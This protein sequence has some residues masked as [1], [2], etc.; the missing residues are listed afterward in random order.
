MALTQQQRTTVLQALERGI[1]LRKACE[2]ADIAGHATWIDECRR[3]DTL[4]DQYA[5]ARQMGY[6]LLADEI[7]EISDDSSADKVVDDDGVV[8]VNNEAVQRSRLRTDS[9]KWLLS[10]MLPKTFGDR[11]ELNAKVTTSAESLSTEELM[12]IAAGKT[13]GG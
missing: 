9:R 1:S 7:L 3:D 8:R 13:R 10:K 2:Q 12:A 4:A 11:L 6:E 5:R